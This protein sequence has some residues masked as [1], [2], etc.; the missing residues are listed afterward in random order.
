MLM[1]FSIIIFRGFFDYL[2]VLFCLDNFFQFFFEIDCVKVS[3][4]F[5]WYVE[6]YFMIGFNFLNVFGVV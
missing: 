3:C 2:K 6:Q 1:L 4:G 5:I